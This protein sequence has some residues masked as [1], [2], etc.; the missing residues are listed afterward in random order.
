[1]HP[2]QQELIEEWYAKAD[3][4]L[5]TCEILLESGVQL[6]DVIAFHA[7]QCAEKYLKAYLT[8]QETMAPKVHDLAVLLGLAIKMDAT[9]ESLQSAVTLTPYAVYTRYPTDMGVTDKEEAENIVNEARL[10]KDFVRNKI[11]I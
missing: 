5:Q 10:V 3:A 6:F 11:G 1:M 2:K 9:F 8:F 4:D 7:Q